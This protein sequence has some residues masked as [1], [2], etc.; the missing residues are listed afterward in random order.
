MSWS[1][2]VILL[3]GHGPIQDYG[4][5]MHLAQDAGRN[6]VFKTMPPQFGLWLCMFGFGGLV[7]TACLE[8]FLIAHE[9]CSC[10]KERFFDIP[11]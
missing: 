11:G 4:W 10:T 7:E 3:C 6:H 9:L 8:R 1:R 5:N 2:A